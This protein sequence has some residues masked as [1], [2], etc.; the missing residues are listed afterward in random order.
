M[1]LSS[2]MYTVY[3]GVHGILCNVFIWKLTYD[4]N[5]FS[6]K[7]FLDHL[8][9]MVEGSLALEKVFFF[10]KKRKK[11]KLVDINKHIIG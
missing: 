5:F 4:F 11:I 3:Y 7:K 1:Y 10:F 2:Y 8:L 9:E 6:P